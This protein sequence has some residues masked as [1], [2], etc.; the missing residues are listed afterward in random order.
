MW[1]GAKSL[2]VVEDQKLH[3]LPVTEISADFLYC[4]DKLRLT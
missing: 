1:Y 4:D 3:L 2:A